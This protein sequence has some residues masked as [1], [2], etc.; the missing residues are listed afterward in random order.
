MKESLKRFFAKCSNII[1]DLLE[2]IFYTWKRI[3]RKRPIDWMKRYK[4]E[5]IMDFYGYPPFKKLSL[6]HESA[7]SESRR[8]ELVFLKLCSYLL[9]PAAAVYVLR[10]RRKSKSGDSRLSSTRFES[11][12]LFERGIMVFGYKLDRGEPEKIYTDR[13]RPQHRKDVYTGKRREVTDNLIINPSAAAYIKPGD[14]L[15]LRREKNEKPLVVLTKG[16]TK[17]S[18]MN[19]EDSEMFSKALSIGAGMYAVVTKNCVVQDVR[20]IEFDLWVKN[21]AKRN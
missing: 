9:Y 19:D 6:R 3:S 8:A 17:V 14:C 21:R 4:N 13:S 16:R 12:N 20:H 1:I 11:G 18:Y 15:V 10:R 5:F 2:F 7:R